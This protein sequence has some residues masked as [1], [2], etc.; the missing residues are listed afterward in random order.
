MDLP[1][2]EGNANQED[3]AQRQR[4]RDIAL[5]GFAVIAHH[6]TPGSGLPYERWEVR[7]WLLAHS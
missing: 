3:Y 1:P 5:R 4:Q 7:D 2:H 6:G